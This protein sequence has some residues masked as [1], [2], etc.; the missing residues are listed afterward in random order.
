MPEPSNTCK[1]LREMFLDFKTAGEYGIYLPRGACLDTDYYIHKAFNCA[2]WADGVARYVTFIDDDDVVVD[3]G[4]VDD[5]TT[6]F[7]FDLC[8]GTKHGYGAQIAR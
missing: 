1:A 6:N 4:V 2:M 3:D 5:V 7:A 8:A